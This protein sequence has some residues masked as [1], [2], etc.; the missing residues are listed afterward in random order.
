MQF[1]LEH[2]GAGHSAY[3]QNFLQRTAGHYYMASLKKGRSMIKYK[4]IV[5]MSVVSTNVERKVST[6]I[7]V[8]L[9]RNW[10]ILDNINKNTNQQIMFYLFMKLLFCSKDWRFY[11]K[12]L[13]CLKVQKASLLP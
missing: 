3:L 6:N 4:K 8:L 10:E 7:E 9:V 11:F 12:F 5:L 2:Q 13:F 1:S